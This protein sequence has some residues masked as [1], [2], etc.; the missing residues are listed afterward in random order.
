MNVR[1]FTAP[2]LREALKKVRDALG[3]EAIILRNRKV[4][5]GGLLS[6]FTRELVEIVAASPDRH[7][8][9]AKA[10]LTDKSERLANGL[11]AQ[12]ADT[13]ISGLREELKELKGNVVDLAEQVKF[14][15]MP[16]LP[17][18]LRIAYKNIVTSGVEEKLAQRLM[19]EFNLRY[20]GSELEQTDFIQDE[21]R[22]MIVKKFNIGKTE[23]KPQ[24][25]ARI[26]A[27]IGATGV[28]K[29]TTLAKL[30]TS[31]RYWGKRDVALISADTFRV[32][33]IEQLKTFA[34]IASIPLET[35]Y[36]PDAMAN[37]LSRHSFRDGIF[38]DTAGR[39]PIDTESLDELAVFLEAAEPDEI[40]LCL[41]ITTRLREQLDIIRRY[42]KFK[43]T[44]LIF[45]K[46]DESQGVGPLLSI[47]DQIKYPIKYLT[48]GQNVPDDII[49]PTESRLA[50]LLL[51]PDKLKE[52][53]NTH[54]K[55]W[56]E[57]ENGIKWQKA[58]GE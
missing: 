58:V 6:F 14:E 45:T 19:Q 21:L 17:R 20:R 7:E 33:A 31:Y 30:V 25:S 35:V 10:M 5:R 4:K 51:A 1:R 2:T 22:K 44:G 27:F 23:N 40:L 53:Q 16:S 9:P 34:S 43:P 50:D 11:K 28:G 36:Q 29:T 3:E 55:E 56:I 32:A 15:R 54:F 12:P 41:S 26:I 24:G 52:Y 38:I 48:C 42:K 37:A 18:N 8:A 47:Q 39:S 49:M 46:L 57:S 13:I